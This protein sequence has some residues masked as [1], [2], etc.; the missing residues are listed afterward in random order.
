MGL[1]DNPTRLIQVFLRPC[2]RTPSKQSMGREICV[3]DLSNAIFK[4][5]KVC[6]GGSIQSLGTCIGSYPHHAELGNR[7]QNWNQGPG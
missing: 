1:R 7:E 2:D 5:E 6:Q 4:M 3:Q